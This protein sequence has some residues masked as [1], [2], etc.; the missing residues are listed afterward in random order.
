MDIHSV[1]NDRN[2]VIKNCRTEQLKQSFFVKP[3]IEWN[4]L[5]TEVMRAETVESFKRLSLGV[6]EQRHS[7]SF[8]SINAVTSLH[9]TNQK[10]KQKLRT[11]ALRLFIVVQLA[12]R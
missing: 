1:T 12:N 5:D 3:V 11:R 2:F 4:H 10:Q 6:T 9:R 7:L 8:W